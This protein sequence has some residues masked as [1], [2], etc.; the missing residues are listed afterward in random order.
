MINRDGIKGKASLAVP[1]LMPDPGAMSADAPSAGLSI[2]QIVSIL[3]AY[4]KQSLIVV[5][6]VLCMALLIIKLLPKTYSATTTLIVNIDTKDPLAGRDFPVDMITSFVATQTELL[7]SSVVLLPVV[8]RLKLTQDKFYVSGFDG[9]SNGL[10]DY[11]EK[12]LAQSVFVGTGRGGQLLYV[13]AYS[14][15]A[16]KAADVANAV[17]DQ[18]IEQ[19]RRRAN[20]P[21]NVRALRYS[22]ELAELRAKAAIAQD[23]VS[24]FRKQNTLGNLTATTN[25]TDVQALST[26]QQQLLETQNRRRSLEARKAGGRIDTNELTTSDVFKQLKTQLNAELAQRAHLLESLGSQH[27]RVLELNLQIDMTRQAME[28]E[29]VSLAGNVGGELAAARDLESKYATAVAVQQAKLSQLRQT[30]DEGSKLVLELESAT[31]VYKHA[32]DGY[33]QIMFA[34]V[35]NHT[36]VD[37]VSRAVSPFKATSPNKPKLLLLSLAASMI[38]GVLIPLLYELIVDRRLRCSDDI[39]RD[40]GIPVLAR[41]DAVAPAA[42]VAP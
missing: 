39:E 10:R 33:D 12:T 18:F 5:L 36:N 37:V 21:A 27:P 22:E 4:R 38:L 14:R 34:A 15:S 31:S 1:L 30:Q 3:R 42:D 29:R 9:D 13:T 11:A 25:D 23:K 24:E 8:D 6:A 7:T 16:D 17:A 2:Q 32:L 20:D 26:L 19:D 35:A 41:F 28:R 40:F